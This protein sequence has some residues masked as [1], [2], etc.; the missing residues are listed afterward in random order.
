VSRMGHGERNHGVGRR[1]PY[2]APQLTSVRLEA[3]QVLA[4]GC[5]TATGTHKA[6][7]SVI[8][9]ISTGCSARG[10]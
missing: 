4:V 3:D 9:C 7:G 6:P 1:R 2:E 8:N 5:K 10:S